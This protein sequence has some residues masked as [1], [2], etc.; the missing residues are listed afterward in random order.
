M[1]FAEYK[2]IETIGKKRKRRGMQNSRTTPVS[3]SLLVWITISSFKSVRVD[4]S[5]GAEFSRSLTLFPKLTGRL[6]LNWSGL[7]GCR[8]IQ[9]DV[10]NLSMETGFR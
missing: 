10:Q 7:P 9:S 2:N 6:Q 3:L 1:V 8:Q 4:L 5:R